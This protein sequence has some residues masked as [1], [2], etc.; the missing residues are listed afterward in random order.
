MPIIANSPQDKFVTSV[1]NSMSR[2]DKKTCQV[3]EGWYSKEDM[4]RVLHWNPSPCLQRTWIELVCYVVL[5]WYMSA[6]LSLSRALS[7][8]ISLSLSLSL[9][10]TLSVSLSLSHSLCLSLSLSLQFRYCSLPLCA[11]CLRTLSLSSHIVLIDCSLSLS[12]YL[13]V[14]LQLDR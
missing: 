5:L 10:L 7:L 8:S 1:Q 12:I 9:S 4:S 6:S 11:D 2:R 14:I 13:Y 3:E